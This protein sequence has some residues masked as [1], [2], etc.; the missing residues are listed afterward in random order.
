MCH[1]SSS[2]STH[3][4][5]PASHLHCTFWGLRS[6]R[7]WTCS[8]RT[9]TTTSSRSS[10]TTGSSYWSLD[11]GI[12]QLWTPPTTK[13]R[14]LWWSGSPRW[15]NF[16][17]LSW[18]PWI[19]GAVSSQCSSNPSLLCWFVDGCYW[20]CNR[21]CCL[22]APWRSR[23]NK[24]EC[25]SRSRETTFYV[26]DHPRKSR[27]YQQGCHL[28]GDPL[29]LVWCQWPFLHETMGTD[30]HYNSQI[31]G[32]RRAT[33][34][35]YN[36]APLWD[37]DQRRDAYWP[38]LI[39]GAWWLC[40][41]WCLPYV[42]PGKWERRG[43]TCSYACHSVSFHIKYLLGNGRGSIQLHIRIFKHCGPRGVHT[44][45]PS[46]SSL[47]T[48]WSTSTCVCCSPPYSRTWRT[49]VY[50]AWP[51]LRYA[52]WYH[53]PVHRSFYIDYPQD[54]DVIYKVLVVPA[55]LSDATHQVAFVV[56]HWRRFTFF[57]ATIIPSPTTPG[58]VLAALAL[59]PWC[60]PLQERCMVFL[61][62]HPWSP[63]TTK[64]A[65]HGSYVRIKID[66]WPP[67][68]LD[69]HLARIFNSEDEL[70]G[71]QQL[72]VIGLARIRGDTAQTMTTRP[73][74]API[75]RRYASCAAD[76]YWIW[77]GTIMSLG[78][79]VLLRTICPREK[80]MP[81]PACWTCN[82][83][84]PRP[85]V[86]RFQPR[87]WR[88]LFF[89][90][91]IISQHATGTGLQISWTRSSLDSS[92]M[93]FET[94]PR[95]AM[96]K[97]VDMRLASSGPVLDVCLGLPPPGNPLENL[98][99][100]DLL[101]THGDLLCAFLDTHCGL[102]QLGR[103][104]CAHTR[105]VEP[106]PHDDVSCHVLPGS[107][108]HATPRISRPI[109]TP[110]RTTHSL[111]PVVD[112]TSD[113]QFS[114]GSLDIT[115]PMCEGMD[116]GNPP[117]PAP[118]FCSGS[119]EH[120]EQQAAHRLADNQVTCTLT[121]SDRTL[122]DLMLSWESPETFTPW[123]NGKLQE[124]LRKILSQSPISLQD[125]T[126]IQIFTDGSHGRADHEDL[127]TTTWAFVILGWLG[128]EWRLIDWYGDALDLD[129]LSASWCGAQYD[130]ILEGETSALLGAYLWILQAEHSV[131]FPVYSDSQL[132]LNMTTGKFN[133]RPADGLTL[134]T[135]ATYQLLQVSAYRTGRYQVQHVRAHQGHLGNELADFIAGGIRQGLLKPRPIPR[136]YAEWFHGNPPRI[137]QAG[138]VMDFVIRP[139]VLPEIDGDEITFS[140]GQ[141][142]VLPPDW[143]PQL[144]TMDKE[145]A[146]LSQS[147]LLATFNVHTLRTKGG[148]AYMRAQLKQKRI[149]LIGL[150]ET[151]TPQ[152]ACYDS[153]YIRFCAPA[154]QGQGGTEIWISSTIPY[155]YKNGQPQFLCRDAVQVL[156]SEAE[157]IIAEILLGNKPIL[158]VVGH[159]PHKGYPAWQISEWWQRI[160]SITS[161]LKR[162][163]Q[164]VA[165]FDANASVSGHDPHFGQVE[166]RP[167]DAAGKGLLRYCQTHGLFAP[168][169][170]DQWHYGSS[171]TWTSSKAGVHGTRNDYVLLDLS[172]K[173]SCNGSWTDDF[174]DAGHH[175]LD[176]SAAIVSV[177]WTEH[178][179]C[180]KRT[181]TGYDRQKILKATEEDW[182]HFYSTCPSVPWTTDT[183]EHASI[184]EDF[185]SKRLVQFFPKDEK[186][187]RNS[188]FSE[189]TWQTYR[190]KSQAK[191]CLTQCCRIHDNWT[192][193][194]AWA[195]WNRR[196]SKNAF[197]QNL[198]VILRT[199][200]RLSQYRRY[201]TELRQDIAQDRA[202]LADNLV[203]S[204]QDS[205]GKRAVQLLRPLRLG[206]RFRT[207]GLK[208]TPMIKKA[209]GSIAG[210]RQE[211]LVRW[212]QH[213]GD[214]EGG[215][216]TTPDELWSMHCKSQSSRPRPQI[217]A[218]DLPTI[219]ELEHQLRQARSGKACG[220]DNIPGELL[221]AS[222]THL[223]HHLWPLLLKVT[224]RL[225]EPLQY[226][227]GKLFALYKGRGSPL[228]CGSYR[229]IL[230]SSN[231]G[232][233]IHNVF[234]SRVMPYLQSS[235]TPL[236][237]SAQ[238]GGM[239]A[240]AAHSIRLAQGR[241]KRGTASDFTMF[242]D[243]ASAY[244]TL[245]RQHA[246]DLSFG[247][248]DVVRF[249]H[250][251]G[252]ADAHIESVAKLLEST[253]AFQ[254]IGVPQHL[255]SMVAEIHTSTWFSVCNDDQLIATSKGT[256]PGDA[257]ADVL[258]SV[259]FNRFLKEVEAKIQSTGAIS[260]A[261]WNGECG[262]L[263]SPGDI[264]VQGACVTWADDIA[265][266]GKP[267]ESSDL[268]P[269][270]QITARIIFGEL[271]RLGLRPNM[272]KG[273]TELILTPRGKQRTQIRQ[274]IHHGFNGK[275]EVPEQDEDFRYLRVVAH[276][277]HLGGLISHCGRMKGEVRRRLAI[278]R[279]SVKDLS[280][281]IYHNKKVSIATR[282]AI[283]RATTWP[284][285]IY[286]AGTWLPLTL[287]ESQ[288]WK[289]GV[290]RIYRSLLRHHLSFEEIYHSTDERIFEL[291]DLPD[292]LVALRLCRL[293]YF[294]QALGRGNEAYWALVAEEH[295]W[296][297]MVK[298]DFDWL[299]EQIRG[300]THLPDPRVD[301]IAWHEEIMQ[302]FPRWKGLLKRAERH[303]HLQSLVRADVK[304]FNKQMFD[305][306]SGMGLQGESL[307]P[308]GTVDSQRRGHRCLPCGR[309]F[310]TRCGWG[311]HCF[312]VHGR[313]N[314]CR[315]LQA[316]Q[317]CQSCGRLY[318]SHER[319][320]R[321]LRTTPSCRHYVA[322]L[323]LWTTPMPYYGSNEVRDREV[324]DSMIP[325]IQQTPPDVNL[326][327]A[328]P[329]TGAC[330]QAL[331]W[332]SL[333]DWP[334]APRDAIHT[335]VLQLVSL[336]LHWDEFNY[337]MDAQKAYFMDEQAT[338]NLNVLSQMM[339]E[340]FFPTEDEATNAPTTT[341]SSSTLPEDL[342][343]LS[344]KS[345][346]PK[347]RSPPRMLYVLHLFAGV[348]RVGDIHSAVASM[349]APSAGILCPISIDVVLDANRCDL[350]QDSVQKFWLIKSA[351]GF[352][353]MVICGP[354]CETW[355]VSRLRYLVEKS[356]PRPIRSCDNDSL[357]WGDTTL[358]LRELRQLR[359]G[360]LLLQFC[361][362]L[363]ACQAA[364]SNFAILE[365]PAASA[366]RH[367][368]LPP[369]IWRLQIV[370]LLLR[371][372]GIHQLDLLQG[373][374][375]GQSPKP[376]SLLLVCPASMLERV[377]M[378]FAVGRTR[379][380]LP[381]AITMG[382]SETHS[383]YNTAPLKRY[384]AAM[385]RTMAK[386]AYICGEFAVTCGSNDDGI[387]GLAEELEHLYQT[388]HLGELDGA[389]FHDKQGIKWS[390]HC[391]SLFF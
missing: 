34:R 250:R 158:C 313:I 280:T 65:P 215:Q 214:M 89:T 327:S 11:V 353:H 128:D 149:F 261:W 380:T 390:W 164:L 107:A 18:L 167:F 165:F 178:I 282:I 199:C 219:L 21:E 152:E 362:R 195:I 77:I 227:G 6:F 266:Y 236:Q 229:A 212:R 367:G 293:R 68:G 35:L 75:P 192:M 267:T 174:V 387:H 197:V 29:E 222:C 319:L 1:W 348:K 354:P 379:L 364:V 384:P 365:H 246:V 66:A 207:M 347:P 271:H 272:G 211:A 383:G 202:E 86:R 14:I 361:L 385:C 27:S 320:I 85:K 200:D 150:Q 132:A 366:V 304:L 289:G 245:L 263:A 88:S 44:I 82:K 112:R 45:G 260:P 157:C 20:L 324:A 201:T 70:H 26:G 147:L 244:Y 346:M 53:Y 376:T 221:Q 226:K 59:L 301:P 269:A 382:R 308:A 71:W 40:A 162:S 126:H 19:S 317:T 76:W 28:H 311:S 179:Q 3:S 259:T 218:S 37:W 54:D 31:I 296:L 96:Y 140:A 189:K 338:D 92:H 47:Y 106:P 322:S 181:S 180:T 168:S 93:D 285:L 9:S 331:R 7:R 251:M 161:R 302:R 52:T 172:W 50:H 90:Y 374:Y 305:I 79:L 73:G 220:Y 51:L 160:S 13:S 36:H 63:Q 273:K 274:L 144:P 249:L 243:I 155:A 67:Q 196:P 386:M 254:E 228:E 264:P 118:D 136:H 182:I 210:S 286:N 239:V 372:P 225:E 122:D 62:G 17:A 375:G 248:E 60:G 270:V 56:V 133:I 340:L 125:A 135:R 84:T 78:T 381:K 316:G 97:T 216:Y 369:S 360:N 153:D 278:A 33:H 237:Y 94:T 176:H 99:I 281:K 343:Q 115:R 363:V 391:P 186:A 351:D 368:R 233:C 306:L 314:P 81:L 335:L 131:D 336:P 121:C 80:Y 279:Q 352:I 217:D 116:F 49:S 58:H 22:A 208:S 113:A 315:T 309:T 190:L 238:S 268:I 15:F 294:G 127:P 300:L 146:V 321:H 110:A 297:E 258:W 345:V 299:Y 120:H 134:N 284:T 55:D 310:T 42:S 95:N 198:L 252:I 114:I 74:P 124:C 224:T 138:L 175:M 4:V 130:T 235:A 241:A 325:W 223:A 141:N 72:D 339:Q 275:V 342:S 24:K 137:L 151:R 148:V 173:E 329:L 30:S 288:T 355:S 373:H 213:F 328:Q 370:K 103:H 109:A 166:E 203:T 191:R 184:I 48:R 16:G 100:R 23:L 193:A 46:V 102:L 371:H 232:K 98:F 356:G 145:T 349:P 377:K 230:L 242:L 10:S 253:P 389:D 129:P 105:K 332:T 111:G 159:G 255:H 326:R 292:P 298:S 323:R 188:V 290:M 87:S 283:F 185:L 358:R 291:T 341:A 344:F 170:F 38:W 69:T 247:D 57:Q 104:N 43:T 295:S 312:K 183:T 32:S 330:Y 5:V 209:D 378:L 108:A 101:T 234:R 333:V 169:T 2:P 231:L 359:V 357:L 194:R 117:E 83:R 205:P 187:K 139:S 240:M 154:E 156:H 318:P 256:R 337:I 257:F 388:T 39:Y 25:K 119:L 61:D 163:R 277:N 350:L 12:P 334:T 265:C 303:T 64:S 287:A 143:L 206:K 91:L 276:Y 142:P 204:L 177:T 171:T 8:S 41:D 123:H 307:G 262:L